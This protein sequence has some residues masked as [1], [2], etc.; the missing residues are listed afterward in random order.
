MLV[1][2]KKYSAYSPAA[3]ILFCSENKMKMEEINWTKNELRVDRFSPAKIS[4]DI[5]NYKS[6]L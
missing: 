6:Y 3:N 5:R 1:F 2:N 4:P